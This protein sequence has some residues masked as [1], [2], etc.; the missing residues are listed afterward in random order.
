MQAVQVS[1]LIRK[2][3]RSRIIKLTLGKGQFIDTIMEAIKNMTLTCSAVF[4][5]FTKIQILSF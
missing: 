1:T 2:I 4:C 3:C 5:L